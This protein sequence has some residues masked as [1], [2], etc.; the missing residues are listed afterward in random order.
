[1]D[2][3]RKSSLLHYRQLDSAAQ[4]SAGTPVCDKC[5]AL[6]LQ[7]CHCPAQV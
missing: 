6:G 5:P 1:M 2:G 7:G 4:I 3:A